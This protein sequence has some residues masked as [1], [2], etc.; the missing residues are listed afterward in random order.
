ML[1]IFKVSI[2]IA[3]N[4]FYNFPFRHLRNTPQMCQ[5]FLPNSQ[6]LGII[7]MSNPQGIPTI[8]P[9][10][11]SNDAGAYVSTTS[12]YKVQIQCCQKVKIL[13]SDTGLCTLGVAR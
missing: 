9:L 12:D 13:T 11:E 3:H 10:R 8:T 6:E 4:F 7:W 2:K 1:K 5:T